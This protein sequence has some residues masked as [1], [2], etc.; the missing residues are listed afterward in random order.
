MNLQFETLTSVV[1]SHDYFQ[2]SK[3]NGIGVQVSNEMQR[4]FINMGLIFKPTADGFTILFD[5]NLANRP[6]NREEVLSK[7]LVCEFTLT[8]KDPEFF[9]YTAG[10][11]KDAARSLYY[12]ANFSD[13]NRRKFTDGSLHIAHAADFVSEDDV[14]PV[15]SFAEKFF[16]KPFGKLDLKIS[17]ELQARYR[18][19]FAA[20][21]TY[22]RYILASEHLTDLN[23][24]AVIGADAA[25]SFSGP[26]K[27]TLPGSK[28]ALAF[29]SPE[30]I[31]WTRKPGYTF[32]L[33][34]NYETGSDKYRVVQALP[35]PA[36]N[37]I[38]HLPATSDMET[39]KDY[40]EIFIY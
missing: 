31:T 39:G 17:P 14:Y 10:I 36:S 24:P 21:S 6:R 16:V 30:P 4:R 22:W 7:P 29:V 40:S 1:F 13:D 18:I 23:N 35:A 8:L 2:G 9:N 27:L 5:S 37:M 12:F 15:S 19:R 32:Q 26:Y 25:Q 33:V 38:S 3:Y 28:E 34:E 11:P 20:R